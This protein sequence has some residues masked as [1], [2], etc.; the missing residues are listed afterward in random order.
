MAIR[1]G[2]E[3]P[4]CRNIVRLDDFTKQHPTQASTRIN[5]C[6]RLDTSGSGYSQDKMPRVEQPAGKTSTRERR[7]SIIFCLLSVDAR[8]S[9]DATMT[10]KEIGGLRWIRIRDFSLFNEQAM[11]IDDR[12][13]ASSRTGMDRDARF[14]VLARGRTTSDKE[15]P[16]NYSTSPRAAY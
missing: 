3:L 2:G 4:G 13:R 1:H 10:K 14:L 6:K 11:P 15:F 12:P 16:R 9:S 7:L 5:F 8:V